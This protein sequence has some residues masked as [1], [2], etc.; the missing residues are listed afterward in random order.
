MTKKVKP[1]GRKHSPKVIWKKGKICG[2]ASDTHITQKARGGSATIL[3][4]VLLLLLLLRPTFHS[5]WRAGAAARAGTTRAIP[6]LRVRFLFPAALFSRAV[7]ILIP[8]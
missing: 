1:I 4:A 5:L 3:A 2:S 8:S 7:W 6:P